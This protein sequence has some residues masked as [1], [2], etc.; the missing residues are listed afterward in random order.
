MQLDEFPAVEVSHEGKTETVVT[1]YHLRT[2]NKLRMQLEKFPVVEVCHGG[3]TE[4]IL[5][6]C[7]C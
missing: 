6:M 3:N 7:N 1:L 2:V 4:V 5:A